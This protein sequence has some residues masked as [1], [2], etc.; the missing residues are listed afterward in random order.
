M[1][2]KISNKIL[3]E[4]EATIYGSEENEWEDEQGF[5]G[6]PNFKFINT[7]YEHHEHEGDVYV[8]DIFEY[9]GKIYS[10]VRNDNSYGD[11]GLDIDTL[12]EVF[13]VEKTVTV[14]E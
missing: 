7:V 2:K 5:K 1:S 9:K 12:R 8:K 13:P 10:I 4:I 6:N 11:S 14:Y 3:A